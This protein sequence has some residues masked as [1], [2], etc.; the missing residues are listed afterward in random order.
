MLENSLYFKK[1]IFLDNF[2]TTDTKI[3]Q[4]YNYILENFCGN[5]LKCIPETVEPNI[6]IYLTGDISSISDIENKY[7]VKQFSTGYEG[8]S[9]IIDMGEVPIN[10]NNVGI[11]FRHFYQSGDY[12]N[13]ISSSHVF[14][15]LTESNKDGK[16]LRTG[17]Y[18][19]NVSKE[20]DDIRFNLLRCSTNL[21]GSTDNFRE[22]DHEIIE[23]TNTIANK[24]LTQPVTLNHVLAQIY[25]NTSVSNKQHKAIIKAHS[26]KTKD[27]PKNAI[28]CFATFY[29][30]IPSGLK[31]DQYD[32][33][34]KDISAL[35]SIRFRLKPQVTDT[36]LNKD[37]SV[38]LYPNSLLIIPL[39]TNRLYTHEI[40]PSI[41]PIDKIPTRLG[42]VIR[43]SNTK[44]VFKQG[45]TYIDK[46]GE[47]IPL[48]PITETDI[49]YLR[50]LY[51]MENTTTEIVNY[52]NIDYSMNLGDYKMPIL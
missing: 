34:Y 36:S 10:I 39:S 7:I 43:C 41:L 8:L 30:N 22:V 21:T 47:L 24:F 17:L 20:D 25:H 4:E 23:K 14:Q 37:F 33:T 16:A 12:F 51:Y 48:R 9:N 5:V 1:H 29:N 40:V 31:K 18:I 52:D 13:K 32:Y 11:Y 46:D 50:G 42:Y 38:R 3:S 6:I 19:T 35:T 15:N 2:S 44:A 27:M 45:N 26:D 49:N 28:M